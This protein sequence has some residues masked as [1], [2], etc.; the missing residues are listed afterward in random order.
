MRTFSSGASR[1]PGS[2]A[3]DP[4]TPRRLSTPLLTPFNST[5]AGTAWLRGSSGRSIF[6][7]PS[8]GAFSTLVPI[9]PRW[10]GER[11]SLRTLP[12]AS[13]RPPLAFNP[14]PRRL[15]TPTDAFQLHP[16][17]ALY[18]TT[19]SRGQGIIATGKG[20]GKYKGG[21]PGDRADET[22]PLVERMRSM[23]RD[24]GGGGGGGGGAGMGDGDGDGDGGRRRVL[25]P[26]TR[27]FQHPARAEDHQVHVTPDAR[28]VVS[29]PFAR[30][31][32]R[33]LAPSLMFCWLSSCVY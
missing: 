20:P 11:R 24:G 27:V 21:G 9:R 33:A 18:G 17:I 28:G 19:L 23:R 29:S 30:G 4:D 3:F 32:G 5:Q 1:R 14:R 2:L 26:Q 6:A 15:S 10:R 22:T 8:S 31:R 7:E 16:D 13:L 12:G 25:V